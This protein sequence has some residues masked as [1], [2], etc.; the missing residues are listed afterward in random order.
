MLDQPAGD[1]E[2]ANRLRVDAGVLVVLDGFV[3]VF[4]GVLLLLIRDCLLGVLFVGIRGDFIFGIL[5][6]LRVMID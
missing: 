4:I 6:L 2:Y 3:G 1:A 5:L